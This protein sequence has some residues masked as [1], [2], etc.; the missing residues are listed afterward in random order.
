[1]NHE[2][3]ID[4]VGIGN[5][6][7][8]Y[9]IAEISGNHNGD[10]NR[11]IALLREA[12]KAGASAVKLQ[13]YTAD[14]MTIDCDKPDF[15]IDGGLWDGQQLY[16]LYEWA[17]T[18]WEWHQQLFDEAAKLGITIFSSPFDESAVELLEQLG[19]P[20]YKIASFELT[21]VML[22]EKVAKTGKPLI[23]STGMAN[24]QEI[25]QAVT[26]ARR[27]G[28]RDIILLHCISGYPTPI[29]QSNL[30]SMVRLQQDFDCCIGLSD[31]TL[32]V[33]AAVASVALGA[34]VIEK[35][36]TLKREDGG[37]DA[38]F[39]LEPEELAL[40]CRSAKEAWQALGQGDY[41]TKAAESGNLK[42]RRSIYVVADMKK[43]EAFSAQ[44]IR[45]IRPGFG[46]EP[47]FYDEVLGKT[48]ACDIER[49]SALKHEMIA[50]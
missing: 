49:G 46:L 23:M 31:H 4:G 12:K 22:I 47:K 15:L 32:G 48:A 37:P 45:R 27:H 35:H 29:E 17:H 5:N 20:A 11:A 18:P 42:F 7:P 38:A 9:V 13:T 30:L 16:Q 21:D 14:T 6:H 25:E 3:H 36:F 26:T 2:I 39:S 41:T 8:P 10:I 24:Q 28:A 19:A 33:T 34:H 50:K 1:M 44:N 40:L 43:G